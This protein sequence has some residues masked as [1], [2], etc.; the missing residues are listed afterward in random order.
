V[1]RSILVESL[2]GLAVAGVANADA[3]RAEAVSVVAN[4]SGPP[5]LATAPDLVHSE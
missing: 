2:A 4:G 1:V 3:H 5:T